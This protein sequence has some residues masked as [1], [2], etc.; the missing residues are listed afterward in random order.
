MHKTEFSSIYAQ[1]EV[2]VC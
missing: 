1:Y 2:F